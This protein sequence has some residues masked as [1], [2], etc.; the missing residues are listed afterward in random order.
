MTVRSHAF[1]RGKTARLLLI[2]GLLFGVT[3]LVFSSLHVAAED[4]DTGNSTLSGQD[5][6][7]AE[8]G[9]DEPEVA[10][11]AP[12]LEAWFPPWLSEKHFLLQ[13][14]QWLCLMLLI[15]LGI[16]A[17]RITRQ[18]LAVLGRM[19]FRT[20]FDD[21]EPEERR[22]IFKP[23]GLLAQA[24]TWFWGTTLIGLPGNILVILEVA[25]KFF[26]VVAAIWTTFIMIDLV[27]RYLMK[28]AEGTDTKFDDLLLPLVSK[29]LKTFTICIGLILFAD[30]FE[31][32]ITALIGGLGLGGMALALAS[33]DALGNV[34]GS[35]LVLIDRPFEIGDWIIFEDHEGTVES[36][37]I[38]STRIRTFYNS[39]VTVPNSKFTTAIVDNMGRRE[40]R[41]L[42][43]TLGLEYDTTPA[44]ITAFCEGV[45]ELIRQHP[46]T[47]K[48]L[49][50]VYFNNFGD[51][52]LDVLLL[53]FMKCSDYGS[54]LQERQSLFLGIIQLA[55]RLGVSFAFP[56]RT[57][58]MFQ[59]DASK[60]SPPSFEDPLETGRQL[61]R[62]ISVPLLVDLEKLTESDMTPPDDEDEL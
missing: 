1:F 54:E 18:L 32:K 41:R 24:S 31:L 13:D 10:K 43:T 17:D 8:D 25:V 11:M 20:S 30:V 46:N 33:Q 49:F 4:P 2:A 16:A 52:S 58:H 3:S 29:V 62:E 53:C 5:D 42:R 47:R 7:S 44:Q 56:T 38:R 15:F 61:A 34:F 59:Q 35:F 26:T 9:V 19:V 14:S 37:G 36:M 28:K 23:I 55:D 6:D 21:M 48:D 27:M 50:H 22:R 45:R 39:Q 57:I 51:N 40:F 12:W 60:A